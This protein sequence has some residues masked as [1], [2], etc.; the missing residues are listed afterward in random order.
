MAARKNY[1]NNKDL[2][3][4]LRKLVETGVHSERLHLMFYEMAKRIRFKWPQNRYSD[5]MISTAYL[6][7]LNVAEK[8]DLERTQAFSYFTTVIHNCYLDFMYDEKKQNMVKDK[9]LDI[10]TTEFISKHGIRLVQY[11]KSRLNKA[12]E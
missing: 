10:F 7:C 4:E 2:L 8:F 5:D 12:A 3:I 11:E 1:V 6:K 9:A